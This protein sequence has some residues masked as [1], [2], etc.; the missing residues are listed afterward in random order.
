MNVIVELLD[1]TRIRPSFDPQH[2]KAVAEFY[3]KQYWEGKIISF[4]ILLNNGSLYA[5]GNKY[6]PAYQ[7]KLEAINVG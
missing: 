1:G 5:Y 4:E 2:K 7:A 3:G 6:G